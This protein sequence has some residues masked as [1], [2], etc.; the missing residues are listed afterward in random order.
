MAWD[1]AGL[2]QLDGIIWAMIGAVACLVLA[3]TALS[4]A[5]MAWRSFLVPGATTAALAAG[6]WFYQTS[7]PDP[8]LAGAL[9]STAQIVAFAAVG[10]P[11]SYIAASFNF[12]LYDRWLDAADQALGLDWFG[13]LAWMDSHAAIRPLFRAIYLSLMPQT[14]VVILVLALAGRVTALRI[15]VLAFV[16]AALV[17]I[18]ISALLPAEGI[19]LLHGLKS[20]DAAT[21]PVSH[22]SWPVFLGLRDGTVRMLAGFGAEGII[23]FP[24][25]HAALAV[26]LI[27]AFWP[28]SAL[29]WPIAAINSLMLVATPI[30]GSHYFIDVLAGIAVAALCLTAARAL[31]TRLSGQPQAALAPTAV[32]G[33][34]ATSR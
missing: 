29:R 22:T 19:W 2:R 34:A 28:I 32:P 23:T 27:A 3:S 26:I 30:D 8:R 33:L 9:G 13:L 31:G 6:Q 12:P 15:F 4:D 20:A 14:L 24:S 16:F 7:R 1:A 5:H 10:A 25:L 17:T 11:L 18:A 21:L